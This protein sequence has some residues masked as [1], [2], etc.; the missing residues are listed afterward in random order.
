MSS[1][2]KQMSFLP[3]YSV[4]NETAVPGERPYFTLTAISVLTCERLVA[5]SSSRYLPLP[6]QKL[7][8]PSR[9]MTDFTDGAD[10]LFSMYGE[11]AAEGDRKLAENWREDANNIMLLVS[12][13]ILSHN[14]LRLTR[15]LHD[16][17]V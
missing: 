3:S 6:T 9:E 1:D 13:I 10:A 2:I 8:S 16:R 15:P 5:S 12:N 14:F 4:S 7:N 17:V 11:M